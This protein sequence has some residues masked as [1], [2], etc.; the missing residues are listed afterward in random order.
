MLETRR[1]GDARTAFRR[2]GAGPLLLL[3]HG[4][5]GSHR[6][7]DAITPHLEPHFTVLAYDQRDCGETQGP[8][9]PA[10]LLQLADDAKALLEALGQ[11]R[12]HV[13][14]TSFGGR[15]AQALAIRHPQCVQRLVLGSTWPLPEPLEALNPQG[16]ARIGELRSGLPDTAEALAEFFF[17]P[18]FLAR[19]PQ[20]KDIFR[21]AQPASA[22]SQ[23]RFAAVADCPALRPQQIR[24]PTLLLAGELDR[25]VPAAVTLGMATAIPSCESVS[26]PGVG[27]AGSIQ[28]P[29]AIAGHIRR[30]CLASPNQES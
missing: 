22:R 10:T 9:T 18:A 4:A 16:V 5:E 3:M 7:F 28:A 23:R 11:E 17:T 15:V 30:F 19:Q 2:S 8:E 26:L 25:V 12:A 29:E 6:M 20:W 21:S 27:H 24:V 14:G 1:T 13:Y